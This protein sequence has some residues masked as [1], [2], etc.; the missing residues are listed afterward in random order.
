M[1]RVKTGKNTHRRH[2]K[3]FELAKG[4]RMSRHRLYRTAQ[5]AVL[6]AG[7]YAFMGRKLKKRDFRSLWI[8]R[9]NSSLK[10]LG[11]RYS[12]FIHQLKEKNIEIDRKMLAL[13][14]N[15]HPGIFKKIVED[16]GQK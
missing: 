12:T 9:M 1:T 2:K 7:E 3:V 4:Y 16:A 5:E 8:V 10:Q 11:V 6:H 14:A 15:E 13:M